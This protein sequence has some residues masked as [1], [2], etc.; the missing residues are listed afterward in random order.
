VN[1]NVTKDFDTPAP[2]N[3]APAPTPT[4]NPDDN[5]SYLT[6][7][8]YNGFFN[9]KIAGIENNF[10]ILERTDNSEVES[11]VSGYSNQEKIQLSVNS[12]TMVFSNG[13][14]LSKKEGADY[15]SKYENSYSE[16]EKMTYSD[17]KIGDIVDV[18]SLD[19]PSA[20]SDGKLSSGVKIINV[21]K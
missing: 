2:I 11:L 10:I 14:I 19:N 7:I 15:I 16:G 12:W 4:Q 20:K 21:K 3:P 1:N 17:L 9:Y 8:A 5:I 13:K 6:Y 18:L